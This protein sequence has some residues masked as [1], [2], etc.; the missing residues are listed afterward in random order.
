MRFRAL[1]LSATLV[2]GATVPALPQRTQPSITVPAVAP[3]DPHG[4][5]LLAYDPR[6][7][8]RAVEVFGDL[9]RAD[10]IAVIVPGVGWNLA[11][12]LSSDS[13]AG[14]ARALIAEAD[15]IDPGATV[16]VAV[17][18]GYDPPE[19]I[20]LAAV[21]SERA[22]AG[23]EPLVRFL[24]GLNTRAHRTLVC[25]SYGSVVCGRAVAA[26]APVDD[27]VALA[28]PGMDAGSL[29]DLHT[30]A[31][32]W[33]ARTADDPIRFT[34]HVRLAGL[35]HGTDPTAARFGARVFHT[36]PATGHDGYLA[37]GT[38]SLTNVARIVLGR[39]Q[40]VTLV[41]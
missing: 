23:A 40:E 29:A 24:A 2:T 33:T 19:S 10:H 20:D 8:G 22:S 36:E 1:L 26:G 27:V 6:G 16:A 30:A 18:L 14:A 9:D 41:H 35:G 7:E 39:T 4:G 13:Y 11:K 31:R 32:V 21:R 17:W 15:R 37:T 12:L 5:R 3:V 34:P 25:H 38:G 28:S